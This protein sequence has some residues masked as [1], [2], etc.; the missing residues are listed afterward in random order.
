M[1][2]GSGKNSLRSP[3]LCLGELA[4]ALTRRPGATPLAAGDLISSGTLTTP[5]PVAAGEEWTAEV[6]GLDLPSLTLRFVG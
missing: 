4:E 3:A 2:A 6:E 5:L 1:E